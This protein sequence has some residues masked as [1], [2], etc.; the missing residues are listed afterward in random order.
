MK[1]VGASN[2]DIRNMFIIESGA[3][4]LVGGTLGVLFGFIGINVLQTG[5]TG[6]L[7][8][9]GYST[10]KVFSVPISLILGSL[11]FSTLIA[12]LAGLYPAKRASRLDPIQALRYE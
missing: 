8:S 6:Y 7:Y 3:M 5:L 11:I 9:Q 2:K 10:V 12:V 1:A 4:G